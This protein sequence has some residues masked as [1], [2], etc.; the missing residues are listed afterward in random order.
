M[1]LQA[2][3]NL[4]EWENILIEAGISVTSAK[5]YVQIFSSEHIMRDILPM[6]DHSMLTILKLIKEPQV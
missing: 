6:L 4:H 1:A 2:G 3:Y 5:T